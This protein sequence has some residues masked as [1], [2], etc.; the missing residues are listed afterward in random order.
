[1]ILGRV[2]SEKNI[3]EFDLS[4]KK[5]LLL[6]SC[7]SPMLGINKIEMKDPGNVFFEKK[8]YVGILRYY[9]TKM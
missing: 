7:P 2:R 4:Q 9:V 5:R 6:L 8:Y 3:M 1:M